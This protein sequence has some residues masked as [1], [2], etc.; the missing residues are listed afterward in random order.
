M[1]FLTIS[2]LLQLTSKMGL[3]WTT[4]QSLDPTNVLFLSPCVLIE[5]YESVCCFNKK[6]SI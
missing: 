1:A 5:E 4:L 6:D 2:P 3:K